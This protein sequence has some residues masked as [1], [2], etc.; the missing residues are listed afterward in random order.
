LKAPP[1]Q[2]AGAIAKKSTSAYHPGARSSEWRKLKHL[3][4]SR[5]T[6]GGWLPGGQAGVRSLL[7][8]IPVDAGLLYVGSVGPGLTA[9]ERHALDAALRR[10]ETPTA[11]FTTQAPG[12]P[13][14]TE[15]RFARPVLQADVAH[16]E[17]TVAGHLRQPTWRG[18][19]DP[20]GG[21]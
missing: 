5:V 17:V 12:L 20:A 2:G 19:A 13:R 6:I 11:P 3:L 14:G 18:L 8:G 9:T 10:I 7:I 21:G 15:V 16:L 1:G 4:V